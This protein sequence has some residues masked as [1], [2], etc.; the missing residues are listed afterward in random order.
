MPEA[1]Y[2]VGLMY[3]KGYGRSID[4]FMAINWYVLIRKNKYSKKKP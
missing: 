4:V 3:E 2:M 1:M